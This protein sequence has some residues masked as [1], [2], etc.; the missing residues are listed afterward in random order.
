MKTDEAI[1]A[2]EVAEILHLDRKT[3]YEYAARGKIPCRRLGK[4]FLFSRT[5]VMG[6]LQGEDRD[7]RTR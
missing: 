7:P 5:R 2:D 6:W 1:S 4:R 3:V